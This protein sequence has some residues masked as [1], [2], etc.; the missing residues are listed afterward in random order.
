MV[1]WKVVEDQSAFSLLLFLHGEEFTKPGQQYRELHAALQLIQLPEL[2]ETV[3]SVP[4]I[5]E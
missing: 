4:R 1:E 5:R 2:F 3:R